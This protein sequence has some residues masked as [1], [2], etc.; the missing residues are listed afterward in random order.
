MGKKTSVSDDSTHSV[1]DL[2]KYPSFTFKH[3][4][5]QMVSTLIHRL[6]NDQHV[7]LCN[8]FDIESLR[9]IKDAQNLE[10]KGNN[11]CFEFD[12]VLNAVQPRQSV[13]YLNSNTDLAEFNR[14]AS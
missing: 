8:S 6:Q 3:G 2:S 9:F 14:S 4:L 7:T 10:L 5:H 13:R 1:L 12:Y 11:T